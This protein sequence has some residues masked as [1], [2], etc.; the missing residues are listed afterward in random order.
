MTIKIEQNIQY[1]AR[2]GFTLIETLV[3]ISILLIAIVGP[4][5]LIGD[6]LHRIY[7]AKDEMI[8]INLAQE[9]IEVAR[10]VR[11]TNMLGGGTSPGNWLADLGNGDYIIDAGNI[12]GAP[13]AFLVPCGV[14]AGLPQTVYFHTATDLYRQGS[15]YDSTQFSRVV[16]ISSAGLGAN[17]RKVTS[18]VT[19]RTGG[20]TGSVSVWGYIFK[21]F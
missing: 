9:G 11:D 17:E 15:V 19:W 3:A 12:A 7:Y 18:T 8:A 16:T 10:R 4:I 21:T 5:S 20:G 13:G 1:S 6:A 14:C 2:A